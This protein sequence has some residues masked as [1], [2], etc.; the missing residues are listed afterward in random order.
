M[1]MLKGDNRVVEKLLNDNF[2]SQAI[3]KR[4]AGGGGG[5][6]S[7]S[8]YNQFSLFQAVTPATIMNIVKA[9]HE[10]AGTFLIRIDPISTDAR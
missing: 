1:A 2:P 5:R 6:L 10:H 3:G 8:K 4:R 9:E 7:S